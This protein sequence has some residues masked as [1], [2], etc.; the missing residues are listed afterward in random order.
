MKKHTKAQ[1]NQAYKC[2]LCKAAFTEPLE[3]RTH[4]MLSHAGKN[5]FAGL[6]RDTGRRFVPRS[7]PGLNADIKPSHIST[8]QFSDKT[9]ITE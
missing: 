8:L 2:E 6:K 3:L 7:K 9:G 5:P 1:K 4:F